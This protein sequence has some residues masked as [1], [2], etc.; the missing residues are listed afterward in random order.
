LTGSGA[1]YHPLPAQM[2]ELEA[3]PKLHPD[4]IMPMVLQVFP[5]FKSTWDE[6]LAEWHGEPAGIFN[7]TAEFAQFIHQAMTMVISRS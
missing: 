6:Y 4:R 7:D 3:M 5:S 1:A 2:N